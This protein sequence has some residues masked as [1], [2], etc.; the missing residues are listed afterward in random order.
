MNITVREMS[1]IDYEKVSELINFEDA[2]AEFLLAFKNKEKNFNCVFDD[3]QLV[4][5]V[6]LIIEKNAFLY[7]FIISEFRNKGIG[8]NVLKL[9]EERIYIN[10]VEKITSTYRT[11]NIQS[12]AFA[13]KSG[14][15]RKFS[16]AYMKYSGDRFDIP[17]LLIK[18]YSDKDYDSAHEMYAKAFH[19][20]RVSVGD[21]PD[22]V[23]E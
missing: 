20:M 23:I 6:Q 9:C 1:D 17:E 18:N 22:S 5:I 12:K 2:D 10:K 15:T 21:F 16:S 11:D 8:S 3:D 7:I 13:N 19:E 14:Y 4:G